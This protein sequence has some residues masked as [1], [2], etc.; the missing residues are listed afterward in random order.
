[1]PVLVITGEKTVEIHRRINEELSRLIPRA[2]S[3]TIPNAGHGSP[4]ENPQAFTEVVENFL[5]TSG[6]C[7]NID[8]REL[9]L[10]GVGAAASLLAAR[11]AVRDRNLG[12]RLGARRRHRA[13]R[14]GAHVSRSRSSTSRS[15]A[16]VPDGTTLNTDA[17]AEAIDACAKAGGGRVLVPAGQ[18]S[19]PA[20][21]I[22]RPMSSC[23]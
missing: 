23:T 9:F 19:S 8:R 14:A 2:R 21:F 16:P 20:R 11:G 4:R 17:I 5:E 13:Q 18:R 10:Y 12:R 3:A 6:K 1:M 15:S 22:S 7:E